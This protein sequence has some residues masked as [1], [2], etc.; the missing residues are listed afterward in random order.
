M[1]R[2]GAEAGNSV[3]NNEKLK[4]H[5]S[6]FVESCYDSRGSRSDFLSLFLDC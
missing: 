2:Q 5:V 6:F 4:I 1:S 3:N